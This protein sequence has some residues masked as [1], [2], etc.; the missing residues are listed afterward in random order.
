MLNARLFGFW[1]DPGAALKTGAPR[2]EI[3]IQG[4]PMFEEL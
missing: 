1:N 4:T 3:K 2:N